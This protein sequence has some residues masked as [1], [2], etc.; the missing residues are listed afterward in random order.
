LNNASA[1]GAPESVVDVGLIC[2][3]LTHPDG[4]ERQALRLAIELE[5]MGHEVTVYTPAVD[6]AL[7][8]P[9]LLEKVSLRVTAPR[10]AWGALARMGATA[11]LGSIGHAGILSMVPEVSKSH[12]VL[13][14]HN[15]SSNWAAARLK[16]RYGVPAVWM[17]NDPPFWWYGRGRYPRWVRAPEGAFLWAIDY[18]SARL[19]DCIAVLDQNNVRLIRRIYH[20]EPTLVRSGVDHEVFD[21]AKSH[22][23]RQK[24]G[25]EG[26]F[27]LLLVGYASPL[28]GQQE[29]LEAV[30]RLE[31]NIPEIHLVLA[32]KSVSRVY[33]PVAKSMGLAQR[34]TFMEGFA[35]NVL[36][37]L[38][39]TAD[40]VL[41]PANQ[42]WGLTI[43]EAMASGKP[44]V[45]SNK[46]GVAEIVQHEKTGYIFD[47][48]DVAAIVARVAALHAD[49]S[50]RKEMG[51]AAREFIVRE[52]N[53]R[54]YAESMLSLFKQ[55]AG[56]K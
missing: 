12:E 2:T 37:S 54:R 24:L 32:G 4:G 44:V 35:D 19:M 8:F 55:V 29:A 42:T 50:L 6:R 7:C 53:W 11:R 51:R 16:G 21:P 34:V 38:Y 23:L 46:A 17:C 9:D 39:A 31:S 13:N 30:K 40:V 26:K 5:S 3:P 47:H 1:I 18:P 27:V 14:C 20:R 56:D 15:Y 45:V 36:V 28:K 52:L 48:G 49:A 43:V 41:F 33:G 25:L 22:D 10:G